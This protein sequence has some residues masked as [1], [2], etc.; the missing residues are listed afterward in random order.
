MKSRILF[1]IFSAWMCIIWALTSLPANEIPDINLFGIDKL[2][3]FGV[4][5]VWSLIARLNA[6]DKSRIN[7][8]IFIFMLIMA[9]LDECHQHYIPGR[10]VS[11]YDLLANWLGV[12]IAWFGCGFYLHRSRR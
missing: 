6:K 1:A 5:F 2:A 10:N 9:V 4:Y 3:H 8:G 11:I 7:I 12:I